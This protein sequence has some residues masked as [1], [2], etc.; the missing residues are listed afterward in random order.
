M[1]WRFFD[2]ELTRNRTRP[3]RIWPHVVSGRIHPMASRGSRSEHHE[4]RGDNQDEDLKT[5]TQAGN[6]GLPVEFMIDN[7]GRPRKIGRR[8]V[9]LAVSQVG[10][11]HIRLFDRTVTERSVVDRTAIVTFRPQKISQLTLAAAGYQLAELRPE[12]T[13]VV[14]EL[15]KPQCWVFAGYMSALKMI[16]KLVSAAG[17]A[18][19]S[20]P[21]DAFE[22]PI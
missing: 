19:V 3:A 1:I 6:S 2:A 20:G 11:V 18:S 9:V 5:A 16:A 4:A 21:T 10:Y 15:P 17:D 14:A 8:N 13:V 22:R 12:R 7:A